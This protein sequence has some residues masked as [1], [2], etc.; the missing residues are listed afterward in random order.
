MIIL[1]IYGALMSVLL[2]AVLCV[3][4]M[5]SR[6]SRLEEKRWQDDFRLDF[7]S[8]DSYEESAFEMTPQFSGD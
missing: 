3:L 6:M 7:V 5:G 4:G 8:N 2:P 1:Y